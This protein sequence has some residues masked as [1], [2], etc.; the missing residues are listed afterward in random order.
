MKTRRH[1]TDG[2]AFTEYFDVRTQASFIW[3]GRSDEVQV[4][5]GGSGEPIDH[6]MPMPYPGEHNPR[7]VDLPWF[8]DLC[9][10]H[11]ETLPTYGEVTR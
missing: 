7:R 3:D 4:C 1:D 11:A 6:T 2:G 10:S 8:A 9:R 5:I